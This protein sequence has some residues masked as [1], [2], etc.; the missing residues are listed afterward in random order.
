MGLGLG[1]EG[2][3]LTTFLT[4]CLLLLG[5]L[6]LGS[7]T[8]TIAALTTAPQVVAFLA[9]TGYAGGL[10]RAR[11]SARTVPAAS[12]QAPVQDVAPEA[13]G[14]AAGLSAWICPRP[15]RRPG[16]DG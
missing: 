14:P 3:A 15:P 11:E 6:A 7:L 12:A 10:E 2:G 9:L 1:F 16:F 8:F 5:L 4:L 13:P